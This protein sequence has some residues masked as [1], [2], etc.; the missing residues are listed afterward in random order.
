MV[1]KSLENISRYLVPRRSHSKT[2]GALS[3]SFLDKIYKASHLGFH[4]APG[5]NVRM[6]TLREKLFL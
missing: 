4:K 6:T 5:L 3:K 2:L 1:L